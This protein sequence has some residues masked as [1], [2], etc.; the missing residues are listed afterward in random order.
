MIDP[1]IGEQL[2]LFSDYLEE[3]EQEIAREKEQKA[4]EARQRARE[5]ARERRAEIRRM[6]EAQEQFKSAMIF[7]KKIQLMPIVT[8]RGRPNAG[9]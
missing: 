8:D 4:Q 9:A 3:V 1:R 2:E 6:K 7:M 5:R